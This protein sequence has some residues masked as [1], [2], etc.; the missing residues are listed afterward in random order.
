MASTTIPAFGTVITTGTNTFA[1][2]Q[3]RD[4]TGPNMSRTSVDVS[5]RAGDVVANI[6]TRDVGF[7]EF[8][9][10]MVDPGEI[11]MDLVLDPDQG[12]IANH[13]IIQE[14]ETF[15]ITWPR[16]VAVTT[17]QAASF[18]CAGF[19]TGWDVNAPLDGELTASVT[20]KLSGAPTYVVEA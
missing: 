17:G 2:T 18:A 10:G 16:V 19:F 20:I 13:P 12:V 14:R 4:I 11:S 15:T 1:I 6:G 9:G 5:N 7:M 3:N 8:K